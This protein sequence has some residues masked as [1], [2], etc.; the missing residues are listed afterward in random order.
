MSVTT[1]TGT[2]LIHSAA[3]LNVGWSDYVSL[4]REQERRWRLNN[5]IMDSTGQPLAV[6]GNPSYIE[7]ARICSSAFDEFGEL[8]SMDHDLRSKVAGWKRPYRYFGY[9]GGAGRYMGI[10]SRTPEKVDELL[11]RVPRKG[12][13]DE[14]TTRAF[15]D[16]FTQMLGISM[17]GTA[18]RVLMAKRPDQFLCVTGANRPGLKR[19]FGKAVRSVSDYVEL[20]RK[21]RSFPW[22]NCPRPERGEEQAIWDA[23]VALIDAFVFLER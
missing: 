23:R 8:Q 21:I 20:H 14:A 4:Y 22:F 5:I 15:L 16:G 17:N 11:R 2:R 12:N 6:F 9:I 13:V 3:Q 7:E 10:V 1:N 19:V 18:T